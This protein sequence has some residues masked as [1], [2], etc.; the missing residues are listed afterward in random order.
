MTA[1][2]AD[3]ARSPPHPVAGTYR[4]IAAAAYDGLLLLALLMIATALL[5]AFTGGEAITRATVGTGWEYAYRA[6]LAALVFAYFWIAWTRRG[7]TLGM[8]SWQLRVERVDGT[9]L[10]TADVARR[11]GCAAPL[12]L[13]AI[14]GTA[15]YTAQRLGTLGLIATF[16]P[17]V[18]SYAVL[19]TRRGTLH[20]LLSRT[21]VVRI[22]K[23]TAPR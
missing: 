1:E 14:A 9:A 5:Q 10:R 4:R 6:A 21:R 17:L 2:A 13:L 11:L 18:G 16:A 8:K 3:P 22:P 23:S 20:D 19:W 7:Q 12:Y 15:L